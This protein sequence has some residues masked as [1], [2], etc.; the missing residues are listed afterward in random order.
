MRAVPT[1]PFSSFGSLAE[2]SF[3]EVGNCVGGGMACSFRSVS[4][5]CD[6]AGMTGFLLR[7]DVA[8]PAPCG[9]FSEMLVVSSWS[10]GRDAADENRFL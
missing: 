4:L 9:D 7:G 8:R 10:G 1:T 5:H 3:V 2:P 6:I